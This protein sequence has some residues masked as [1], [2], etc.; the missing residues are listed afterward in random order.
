M[1]HVRLIVWSKLHG[2][3]TL[4]R[5]N[6]HF[7]HVAVGAETCLWNNG[8]V[9]LLMPREDASQRLCDSSASVYPKRMS[10]LA[11]RATPSR[12]CYVRFRL[13]V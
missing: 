11:S 4:A 12:P 9:C 5:V 2:R 7:T 10:L 8:P 3:E 6:F 13:A 1:L